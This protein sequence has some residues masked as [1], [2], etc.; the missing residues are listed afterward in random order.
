VYLFIF[1]QMMKQL[2]MPQSTKQYNK[3]NKSFA[4]GTIQSEC[5]PRLKSI[6]H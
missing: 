3:K 5:E 6:H 2:Y 1:Y 4:F